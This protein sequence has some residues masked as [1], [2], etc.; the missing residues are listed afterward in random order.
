MRHHTVLRIG[1]FLDDSLVENNAANGNDIADAEPK[2][3]KFRTHLTRYFM[4][5]NLLWKNGG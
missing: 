3:P 2:S 1:L 4:V 5:M